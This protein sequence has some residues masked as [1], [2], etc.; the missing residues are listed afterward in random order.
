MNTKVKLQKGKK[1]KDAAVEISSSGRRT[2]QRLAAENTVRLSIILFGVAVCG[3]PSALVRRR[4]SEV[5]PRLSNNADA[6]VY[7]DTTCELHRPNPQIFVG[8][9][10]PGTRKFAGSTV[11]S[12]YRVVI[13]RG[14]R[15]CVCGGA[16]RRGERRQT[17]VIVFYDTFI[18][19]YII[20]VT[21]LLRPKA[22]VNNT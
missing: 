20:H 9:R 3:W 15:L 13:D 21:T 12:G 18:H 16:R 7:A 10:I 8:T 11:Y 4:M 2:F 17:P 1:T 22:E 19:V 5:R 14:G 6:T